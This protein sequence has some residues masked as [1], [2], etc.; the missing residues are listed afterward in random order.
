MSENTKAS[1]E[2]EQAETF[3]QRMHNM[4]LVFKF[5]ENREDKMRALAVSQKIA[6]CIFNY[7]EATDII[8]KKVCARLLLYYVDLATTRGLIEVGENA[9][10]KISKLENDNKQLQDQ[11]NECNKKYEEQNRQMK[12]EN[13]KLRKENS[14]L[15]QLNE[16]LHQTIDRFGATRSSLPSEE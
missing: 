5:P 15:E 2:I 6:E 12:E 13:D 16:A 1:N 11:L 8:S 3:A 4:E 7:G 14:R 10:T 9:I